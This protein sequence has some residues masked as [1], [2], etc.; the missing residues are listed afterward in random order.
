M[1]PEGQLG[2]AG[3]H[4]G[5]LTSHAV[6]TRLPMGYKVGYNGSGYEVPTKKP[7]ATHGCVRIYKWAAPGSNWR[8]L[9]CEDSALT[10]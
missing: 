6:P 10:N 9:P 3:D 5:S 4:D 8:P 2:L 1:G 7:Y